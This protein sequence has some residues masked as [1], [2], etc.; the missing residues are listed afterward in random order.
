MSSDQ[1][2]QLQQQHPGQLN[3]HDYNEMVACGT[4][5]KLIL[6]PTSLLDR[7]S[8]LPPKSQEEILKH[9]REYEEIQKKAKKK[10]EKE[11]KDKERLDILRKEKEKALIEARKIWEDDIIPNWKKKDVK[12][13]KEISWRGLPPAVRGKV[14]KLSI[15]ND[16]RI[17][18]DLF[19]ISLGHA[20]NALHVYNKNNDRMTFLGAMF[21]LNMDKY[22]SFQCL[23]NHINKNCFLPFFRHDQSG[24]TKYLNAMDNTVEALLPKLH[25]HFKEI[26]ISAKNYLMDWITT[27]FSKALP[28]DIATRIWDLVFLEGEIF[29]FRTSL[30]ILR[31]FLSDLETANYDQCIDLFTQLPQRK[32]QEDQF[33]EEISSIVLDQKKFDKLLESK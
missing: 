8:Q 16:L 7:P 19:N 13:I 18:N 10:L 31:M 23:S 22:D 15:G 3:K 12:K 27:L 24:M 33:F 17:T 4:V 14:W 5:E 21:L 6:S 25:R 11:A 28:L 20:N 30:A 9:Q 2:Q 32:I 29:V 26:G 1:Q